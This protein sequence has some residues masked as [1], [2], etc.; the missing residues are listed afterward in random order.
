MRDEAARGKMNFMCEFSPGWSEVRLSA[1]LTR[2]IQEA[3][4]KTEV[5][6]GEELG[7]WNKS[8]CDFLMGHARIV[9]DES[10]E[11]KG[12]GKKEEE[13]RRKKERRGKKRKE[14]ERRGR[15][16]KEEGGRGRKKEGGRKKREK[17]EEERRGREKEE[18][19]R[20][21][22]KKGEEGRERERKEGKEATKDF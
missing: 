18:E 15:E 16:R 11:E 19:G 13:G 22:K 17:K 1:R 12:R 20:G 9:G 10:R 2:E 7:S 4:R 5:D 14:A 21:R 8:E 6:N 3:S